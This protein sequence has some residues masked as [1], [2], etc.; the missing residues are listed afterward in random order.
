MDSALGRVNS[1]L[2]QFKIDSGKLINKKASSDAL[3]VNEK[4]KKKTTGKKSARRSNSKH[5]SQ[6][7]GV[8]AAASSGGS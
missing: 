7:Q 2:N 6:P 1:K 5:K 8:I 4:S 3:D